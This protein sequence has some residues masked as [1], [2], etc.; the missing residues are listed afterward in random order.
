ME[1]KY[2]P[3]CKIEFKETEMFCSRC[4]SKLVD[5]PAYLQYLNEERQKAIKEK[6]MEHQ[7]ALIADSFYELYHDYIPHIEKYWARLD[8]INGLFDKYSSFHP[9]EKTH[10]FLC[11][12]KAGDTDKDKKALLSSCFLDYYNQQNYIRE[13][14]NLEKDRPY[15]CIDFSN[16]NEVVNRLIEEASSFEKIFPSKY[17]VDSYM[18]SAQKKESLPNADKT[19]YEDVISFLYYY[20]CY[21][22]GGRFSLLKTQHTGMFVPSYERYNLYVDYEF[23]G[24][25]V[26][27]IKRMVHYESSPTDGANAL[28]I[29]KEMEKW[30]TLIEFI[31][32]RMD[33]PIITITRIDSFK[34]FP[35]YP[36]K[37]SLD[38]EHREEK[39]ID[40]FYFRTVTI[41]GERKKNI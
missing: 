40:P 15:L 41:K 7:S 10:K 25:L 28:I 31:K 5:N 30:K 26:E 27:R 17:E 13:R 19:F 32:N 37:D 34:I 1:K 23:D 11:K 2:C 12:Y 6:E 3:N 21:Y 39:R 20:K 38:F 22:Y 9:Y 36:V 16:K 29:L 4:G 35:G 24:S 33:I 14:M 18:E 8:E